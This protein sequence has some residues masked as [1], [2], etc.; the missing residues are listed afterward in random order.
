MWTAEIYLEMLGTAFAINCTSDS[1]VDAVRTILAPFILERRRGVP[2]RRRYGLV[3][4]EGKVLAYRDCRK[5]G[6]AVDLGRAMTYV[7]ANLNR[8]A[9]EEYG[10]FAVHAGVVTKEGRT[11][12][13]PTRSGGGKSTL[14]AAFL[15][16]GW[17]Y[18][19]DESLC[20]DLQREAGS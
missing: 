9:I 8:V 6:P 16:N 7:V 12:A 17:D 1:Q 18:V 10:G 3:E 19:S 20:V 15:L 11:L 14:T 13:F 2:Q 5:L 4:T